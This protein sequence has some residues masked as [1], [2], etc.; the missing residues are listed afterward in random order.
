MLAE[1][2][3]EAKLIAPFRGGVASALIRGESSPPFFQGGD[4]VKSEAFLQLGW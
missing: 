3:H 4:A 1:L 2:Q